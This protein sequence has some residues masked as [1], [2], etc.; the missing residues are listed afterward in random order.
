MAPSAPTSHYSGQQATANTSKGAE[1][2]TFKGGITSQDASN[3]YNS[4]NPTTP[5]ITIRLKAT[6]L[7]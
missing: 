4:H 3:I 7:C 2:I 5:T 6:Y 1:R